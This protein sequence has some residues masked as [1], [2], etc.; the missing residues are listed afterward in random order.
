MAT[1]NNIHDIVRSSIRAALQ[2]LNA[3]DSN[4]VV[5]F[6]YYF[7]DPVIENLCS[8]NDTINLVFT[9]LDIFYTQVIIDEEEFPCD[10][11]D[12]FDKTSELC[13]KLH[14]LIGELR[15]YSFDLFQAKNIAN[16]IKHTWINSR[17]YSEHIFNLSKTMRIAAYAA[18]HPDVVL[19]GDVEMNPGPAINQRFRPPPPRYNCSRGGVNR[20]QAYRDRSDPDNREAWFQREIEKL[21]REFHESEATDTSR[22]EVLAK[23]T[24]LLVDTFLGEGNVAQIGFDLN[25]FGMGSVTNSV[26]RAVDVAHLTTQQVRQD[27]ASAFSAIP[28]MIEEALS[29]QAGFIPMEIRTLL[30]CIMTLIALYVLKRLLCVSYDFFSFV[31]TLVKAMFTGCTNI[32]SCFDIWV[33]TSQMTME[34]Q[35]GDDDDKLDVAAFASRWIPTVVPMLLS[36]TVA[37]ALTKVPSRDNSPDAW[38]RRLDLLPRACKGMGDIFKFVQ[39]WFVKASA[40]ARELMY[41]PDPLD[42]KNGLPMITRWM[43]EVVELSKDLAT[44][45][46]TRSGCEKVKN[47]WYRGDKLLKEHRLLMDRETIENVKRMLALAARMKDTAMNTYGRPK[48]V[49]AV[50]QLV[51]LVGESQIGKSTMQYFLAAELLAEFGMAKDIEDQMY[52]RAVE[53][54]YADGYNGQY[55]WVID[56]AFQMRDSPTA[57]NIEFFEIIRAVGNFPYALHMADISQKANTYF[58]SKSLICSTNNA[59]LDIQSL[60]YPDAVFNRFAFAYQVR[61]KPQ[62]QKLKKMHGHD[63]ITLDT[64]KAR[65]DAPVVNGVKMPFNLNVYEFVRFDPCNKNQIDEQIP[66]SFHEM[67]AIL[68][69]DLRERDNQSTGLS[70][71]LK[72]YAARLDEGQSGDGT[73]EKMDEETRPLVDYEE[74]IE[75]QIDGTDE[76]SNEENQAR[77]R[78]EGILTMTPYGVLSLRKLKEKWEAIAN[79]PDTPDNGD[80]KLDAVIIRSELNQLECSDSTMLRDI[81]WDEHFITPQDVIVRC[82][83]RPEKDKRTESVWTQ[84]NEIARSLRQ[85]WTSHTDRVK[86]VWSRV[87]IPLFDSLLHY[88]NTFAGSALI[89]TGTIIALCYFTKKVREKFRTPGEEAESDTRA[90]QPKA[91]IHMKTNA[92]MKFTRLAKKAEMAEDK[93]QQNIIEKIR[94]NQFFIS[95]TCEEEGQIVERHYGNGTIVTGTILMMPC[96]FVTAMLDIHFA[97]SVILRR[98]DAVEGFELPIDTFLDDYVFQEE[99]DVAFINLR[100]WMPHRP[101]I[102]KLFA[103]HERSSRLEGRFKSTLSGYRRTPKGELDTMQMKGTVRPVD[104]LNYNLSNKDVVSIRDAYEYDIDTQKGDCGMILTVCDRQS[105]EKIIGMHVAG[106]ASGKNWASA[107][108]REMI[109][110]ALENFDKLAQMEGSYSHLEPAEVPIKGEF[111]PVGSL[112]DGPAEIAKSNIIPSSLHGKLSTPTC[113]PAYL[114]PFE[115]EGKL[116]DPLRMGA[117]KGGKA[118][119]RLDPEHLR[120]AIDDVFEELAYNHRDTKIEMKVLTHEEAIAGVETEELIHGI[121]RVT[122]PG[123]PYSKEKNR[124]KGKTKWMGRDDYDFTSENAQRLRQDVEDLEKKAQNGERM[125]VLWVDTLKDE[126]RPIAKVEEGKTRVFSNG[127]MHFNILFRKYFQTALTHIQHNRIY[128]GSGV[129]INVWSAEWE[130][131]F[132][133]ITKYGHTAFDGDFQGLDVSLALEALWGVEEILDRLYSDGN[134]TARESIWTNVVNA[135]R[136][137]RGV[138]YQ[139][140]HNV[141]SGCVGTTIIDTIALKICFR[142]VWLM[143]APPEYRSMKAFHEH[144]RM[145]I[146]GD[147][148]V[149]GVSPIAAEFFNMETLIPAFAKLGMVYTDAAKTGIIRKTIDIYDTQFLKRQFK[150]SKWLGRHTCP[151]DMESRLE[152]LNWT[153]KNNVIDTK[154]IEVDTIQN[155]LQEI[156]AH[157]DKKFFDDWAAKILAAARE[158]ELPG[159]VNEGFIYYHI[160]REERF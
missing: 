119:P 88:F 46:R 16:F 91:R 152:S 69:K 54:E 4:P 98:H 146:Y 60:T 27:I 12:D 132:K 43:D 63:V 55:V 31:Y 103:S 34:A 5:E 21:E 111:L 19:G 61:V 53:Q 40:Y 123:Y 26:D 45:C 126:R 23:G 120:I 140:L 89:T 128:N 8:A 56:D 131:L 75:A 10:V 139:A 6:P 44:I 87:A 159:L 93:A 65:R 104:G 52:M 107:I 94:R 58:D 41:G 160:P 32:F 113:K 18:A 99:H 157:C 117:E 15:E 102:V 20:M 17:T 82:F 108:W 124:G 78:A 67:A 83:T 114:R 145:I 70:A 47:L 125:D 106:S 77:E 92:H 147:D 85:R 143:V 127:P 155:V 30:L 144:V 35:I 149:V 38:M 66:I 33:S 59:N 9:Q 96:H 156:A 105:A 112:P 109:E 154:V 141:P 73:V 133:Y 137:F 37:G 129:G 138:I 81:D 86:E 51:W 122:S 71:M 49:R 142:I 150:F 62:Y 134:T 151:A 110:S 135:T 14:N 90:Q 13:F 158:A 68:R 57:P 74:V 100:K 76:A 2:G 3:D 101:N 97:K 22:L 36:M 7:D 24:K 116:I 95:V 84:L 64:A 79:E 42:E 50:P 25:L 80:I 11:D 72:T 121:S 28:A 118:L 153:R 39:E 1:T 136:Y 48:G 115:K 130:A 29:S 148:N